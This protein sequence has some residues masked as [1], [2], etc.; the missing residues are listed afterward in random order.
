MTGATQDWEYL[1]NAGRM[2]GGR[3]D[4][5]CRGTRVLRRRTQYILVDG[6]YNYVFCLGLY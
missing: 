5:S 4:L 2:K 6:V 3:Y 1:L